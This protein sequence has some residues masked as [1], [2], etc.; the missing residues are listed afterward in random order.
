[1]YKVLLFG[2]GLQYELFK[3]QLSV[4]FDVI[5]LTDND[6]K[7]QGMSIDGL[8]VLSPADAV[9]LPFDYVVVL[10]KGAARED[11]LSQLFNLGIHKSKILTTKELSPFTIDP[12]FFSAHLNDSEKKALFKNNVELVYLENNSKCNRKCWFCPNSFIDRHSE[13]IKMPLETLTKVLDELSGIEYDGDITFSYFN[14]PLLDDELERRIVLIKDK[15]PK[16]YVHFASNGDFM[17]L[18][19]LDKLE[20]AGID[21]IILST[22]IADKKEAEWNYSEAVKAIS[23]K[24]ESLTIPVKLSTGEN[25]VI[26]SGTGYYHSL[27]VIFVC[28][29]FN[30]MGYHRAGL[31]DTINTVYARNKV[32]ESPYHTLTVSYTGEVVFCGQC[33]INSEKH[34]N[35]IVGDVN[36]DNI[37]DIFDSEKF[38][39]I[40]KRVLCDNNALPCTGCSAETNTSIL[41]PPNGPFR[42]RPRDK[43]HGIDYLENQL[44]CTF[45]AE[46]E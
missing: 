29:N 35:Y 12:L 42:L 14:E 13:N 36:K 19:R 17:D 26:A 45:L 21:R 41:I 18:E 37:F 23:K 9:S 39:S 11:I 22:Y 28:Q 1:M 24:S 31:L 34:K 33:H 3:H 7:K 38:M 15:L 6:L 8:V 40:R 46:K 25:D 27:N 32:C 2:L 30:K 5:A 43:K 44:L 10:P 20:R 16:C 4:D